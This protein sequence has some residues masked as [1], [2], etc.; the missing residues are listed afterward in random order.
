MS[1][2]HCF[3]MTSVASGHMEMIKSFCN[4]NEDK[5][6]TDANFMCLCKLRSRRSL[7]LDY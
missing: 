1:E 5:R 2:K 7:D 6:A 3:V 4:G